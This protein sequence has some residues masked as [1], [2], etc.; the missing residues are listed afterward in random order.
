[1]KETKQKKVY[2]L[3]LFFLYKIIE[4][5]NLKYSDNN[6]MVR[7]SDQIDRG[8]QVL[9]ARIGTEDK[10]TPNIQSLAC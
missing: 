4:R 8:L 6:L 7:A 1:M 10:Q 9:I 5:G 3:Q 2:K